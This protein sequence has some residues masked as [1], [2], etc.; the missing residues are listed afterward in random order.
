MERCTEQEISITTKEFHDKLVETLNK[1]S[2][3][4]LE[5]FMAWGVRN[6]LYAK[7]TYKSFVK[8]NVKIKLG[9]LCKLICT[10]KGV[11]DDAVEWAKDNLEMLN[12]KPSIKIAKV[13][14]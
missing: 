6:N 3:V 1:C 8:M 5:S 10:T 12:M 11:S 9:T 4:A 13:Y 7:D 14:K 2:T